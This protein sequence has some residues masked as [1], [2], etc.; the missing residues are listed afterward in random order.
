MLNETITRDDF[1]THILAMF[2]SQIPENTKESL[3]FSRLGISIAKDLPDKFM[4]IDLEI[5]IKEEDLMNRLQTLYTEVMD[6]IYKYSAE[7]KAEEEKQ[8]KKEM[9]SKVGGAK[10][11]EKADEV[12][13]LGDI[14]GDDEDTAKLGDL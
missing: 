2:A 4:V 8:K 13:D 14:S 6:E 7:Q 11:E 12:V 10:P 9:G 3:I 5:H 1:K